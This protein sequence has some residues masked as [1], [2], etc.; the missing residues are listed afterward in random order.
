MDVIGDV[1]P[2]VE[3]GDTYGR[4]HAAEHHG[5]AQQGVQPLVA[6]DGLACYHDQCGEGHDQDEPAVRAQALQLSDAPGHRRDEA[7]HDGQAE[8]EH[9]D[10]HRPPAPEG[11]IRPT[12]QEITN[13]SKMPSAMMFAGVPTPPIGAKTRLDGMSRSSTRY[14]V[15]RVT[16]LNLGLLCR[17]RLAFAGRPGAWP[18]FGGTCSGPRG[19]RRGYRR[20]GDR[21]PSSRRSSHSRG[22]RCVLG[23]PVGGRRPGQL[24]PAPLGLVMA[25]VLVSCS[26]G[27]RRLPLRR[28]RTLS[29]TAITIRVPTNMST[30]TPATTSSFVFSTFE[31]VL[32]G[33]ISWAGQGGV[34]RGRDG[35]LLLQLRQPLLGEPGHDRQLLA[36]QRRDL[37]GN[38]DLDKWASGELRHHRGVCVSDTE[39]PQLLD[40]LV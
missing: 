40:G 27:A 26:T 3:L 18:G 35:C 2:G 24:W 14:A 1:Q 23:L 5:P 13:H 39:R 12:I 7:G 21:R 37:A 22:R 25:G 36:H 8:D 29:T 20:P 34:R 32:G 28:L 30:K 6:D 33:T 11:T 17:D 9:R 38:R 19:G 10:P 4:D 16:E 31:G 15:K